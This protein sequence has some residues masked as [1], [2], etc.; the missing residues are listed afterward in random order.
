MLDYNLKQQP[1]FDLLN[2]I[3]QYSTLNNFAIGDG[4]GNSGGQNISFYSNIK[5]NIQMFTG[6]IEVDDLYHSGFDLVYSRYQSAVKSDGVAILSS[7]VGSL[8]AGT[9]IGGWGV[10]TQ[11]PNYL[12]TSGSFSGSIDLFDVRYKFKWKQMNDPFLGAEY[13][14]GSKEVF[15]EDGAN[16]D[17]TGFYKNRG[18]G[19]HIYWLQPID[20]NFSVRLG[21]IN[22]Q[23][24]F[25][26]I[27]FGAATESKINYT[28]YYGN[29]RVAL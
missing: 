21:Y 22:Q 25:A 29:L 16:E 7:A 11:L 24:N 2:I 13:Q 17:V 4:Q 15:F 18:T 3:L 5:L 8:P 27:T 9:P 23:Q 1:A 6:H 26:P 12:S 10:S 20:E 19:Y 14:M 28:S